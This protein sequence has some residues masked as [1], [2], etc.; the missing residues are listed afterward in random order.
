VYGEGLLLGGNVPEHPLGRLVGG[1]VDG[2]VGRVHD[3]GCP[4][5]NEEGARP[6]VSQHGADAVPYARVGA[7]GELQPLLDGVHRR[8]DRV[9]GYGRDDPRGG[10]RGGVVG[11]EAVGEGRLGELVDGE[12]DGV[13]GARAERH[14]RESPVK[15]EGAALAGHGVAQGRPQRQ[16][17]PAR[18]RAGLHVRLQSVDGEHRRV[19]DDAGDGAGEH[20]L[21]EAEVIVGSVGDGGA[22]KHRTGRAALRGRRLL[23]RGGK[24]AVWG[25]EIRSHGGAAVVGLGF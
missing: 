7:A 21:P 10:V 19:L 15:G 3:H 25:A 14:G 1:K 17:R 11:A 23:S 5:G 16:S 22:A 6:L 24:E 4:V 12:V 20:V 13:S 2:G 18:R 9:A 8:E